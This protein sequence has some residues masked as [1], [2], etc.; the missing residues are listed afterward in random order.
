MKKEQELTPAQQQFWHKANKAL[1]FGR[2]ASALSWIQF[3]LQSEPEF[4][5]ARVMAREIAQHQACT[6]KRNVFSRCVKRVRCFIALKKIKALAKRD[7]PGAIIAL[8]SL[9]GKAPKDMAAH[10]AMVELAMQWKPPLRA[11][12]L[13]SLEAVIKVQPKSSLHQLKLASF[14]LRRD[15]TGKAWNPE[16]ALDAYQAVL[17]IDQHH[18]IAM[19]GVKNATA[20][21]SIQEGGWDRAESYRDLERIK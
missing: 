12:A 10:H 14:C 16:R 19:Q 8:E 9:L 3:L 4:L 1:A 13:L 2:Y 11:V 17:T 15:D 6:T 7:I 21:L 5:E 20:L 18:L